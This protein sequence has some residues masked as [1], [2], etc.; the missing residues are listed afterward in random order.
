MINL[1][2]LSFLVSGLPEKRR[3]IESL[4]KLEAFELDTEANELKGQKIELIIRPF[5]TSFS[6]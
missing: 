1:Y 5:V 2:I 6:F 4:L 3:K